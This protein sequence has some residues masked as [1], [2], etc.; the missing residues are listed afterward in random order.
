[1]LLV[2]LGGVHTELLHDVAVALA[3]VEVDEAEELLLSL[4]VARLLTGARGRSALAIGAAAQA[5]S[6]LSRLAACAPWL[7]EIE[8]N[9]L[10]VTPEGAL[11]LDARLVGTMGQP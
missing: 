7:A 9:P 3:P 1:L 8:I 10:L 2:G 6:A 5:A 11:G 4:S